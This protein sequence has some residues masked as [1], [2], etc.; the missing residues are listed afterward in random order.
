ML[1]M[2]AS[3]TTCHTMTLRPSSSAQSSSHFFS[4]PEKQQTNQAGIPFQPDLLL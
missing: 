4:N 1:G 2:I 3:H